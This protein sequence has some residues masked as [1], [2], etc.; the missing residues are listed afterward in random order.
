ME[1]IFDLLNTVIKI[2]LFTGCAY[3]AFNFARSKK[4]NTAK[5]D[6]QNLEARLSQLRLALKA[7]IKRKANVFRTMLKTPI[8]EGDLFDSTVRSLMDVKFETA[9]D[10]QTYFDISRQIVKIITVE[11]KE[12]EQVASEN[13]YMSSDFKTEMDI[14][15]IIKEMTD[16]SAKIN[17]R[18]EEHNRTSSH[19][20]KR[21]DSLMFPS[22]T[23]VNRVFKVEDAPAESSKAS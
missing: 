21:V 5:T 22:V 20:L 12:V 1:F 16:V 23:E 19:K 7:K 14:I 17:H 13:N 3:I 2:S 18:V 8:V 11:N 4:I 15:R 9:D 10:F 6:L